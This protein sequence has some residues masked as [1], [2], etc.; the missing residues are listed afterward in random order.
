MDCNYLHSTKML[1]Y[2]LIC[3]LCSLP[4]L[5]AGSHSS[6]ED[7]IPLHFVYITTKTGGFVVSGGIPIVDC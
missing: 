2:F 7:K 3:L 1:S 6:N 5:S 4:H